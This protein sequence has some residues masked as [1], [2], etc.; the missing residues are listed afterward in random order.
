MGLLIAVSI[1]CCFM[2]YHSKQKHLLPYHNTSKLKEI[3]IYYK[4][5]E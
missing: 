4:N 3:D 5:G 2:K 1:N